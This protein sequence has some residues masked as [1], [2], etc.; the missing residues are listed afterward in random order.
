MI[1]LS[2]GSFSFRK[3]I[4]VLL[5]RTQKSEAGAWCPFVE[6]GQNLSSSVFQ[7][8]GVSSDG[9]NSSE[10]PYADE[11]AVKD[12]FRGKILL[13]GAGDPG[14]DGKVGKGRYRHERTISEN[15]NTA[16]AN[17]SGAL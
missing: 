7:E 17:A 1:F 16:G 3:I 13:G 10:S 5:G 4:P 2:V 14:G 15:D 9:G 12:Q 6:S 8:R 11:R